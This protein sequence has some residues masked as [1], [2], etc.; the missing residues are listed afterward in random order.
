MFEILDKMLAFVIVRNE[1]RLFS[2]FPIHLSEK[3]NVERVRE[4]VMS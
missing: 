2:I 4:F 3:E 1:A